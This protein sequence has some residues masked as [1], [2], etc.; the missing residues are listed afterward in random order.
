LLLK[1]I[2]F[3][4]R[5]REGLVRPGTQ[6]TGSA[7]DDRYLPMVY[8]NERTTRFG[9]TAGTGKNFIQVWL[10]HLPIRSEKLAIVFQFSKK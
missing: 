7:A 8:Q 4:P 2:P 3:N 1:G 10:D 5:R 9:P 6:T